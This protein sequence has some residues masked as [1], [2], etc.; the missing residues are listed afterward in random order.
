VEQFDVSGRRCHLRRPIRDRAG[1]N[2]FHE[3]PVILRELDNLDRRMY[4]VRFNDS[5]ET[6]LFSHEV[7]M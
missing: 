1:R 3:G 2:H 5:I 7:E 4:L 6:L